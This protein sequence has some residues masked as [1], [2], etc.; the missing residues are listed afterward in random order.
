MFFFFN[1]IFKK[2]HEKF[3][4]SL[5]SALCRRVH[6]RIR[7][8]TLQ[9]TVF[10]RI[11][12][13]FCTSRYKKYRYN[14]CTLSII[15]FVYFYLHMTPVKLQICP[16]SVWV[17]TPGLNGQFWNLGPHTFFSQQSWHSSITWQWKTLFYSVRTSLNDILS[18]NLA[19]IVVLWLCHP[20]V[21]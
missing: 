3:T 15:I 13:R 11:T 18:S 17:S 19:M 14:Y 2:L 20:R 5:A 6:A 4:F 12:S 8:V 7:L 10:A 21:I 9:N 1:I 16:S